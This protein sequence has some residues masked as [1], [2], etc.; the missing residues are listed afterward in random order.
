MLA[1]DQR[2]T[3]LSSALSAATIRVRG[4]EDAQVDYL[5]LFR[6]DSII[7]DCEAIRLALTHDYPEEKKQWSVTGQ[8]FGGFCETTYLSFFPEGLK[9][10][11]M[12]GG[13]PPLVDQP[14]Q[15][16]ASLYPRVLK[17]NAEY[18]EK[19][20]DDVARVKQIVAWLNLVNEEA[21]KGQVPFKVTTTGRKFLQLGMAF[22]THGGFDS[23][24]GT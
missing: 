8:S 2:G 6:A 23:V 3:G 15:V 19:Y 10:V 9:E 13:L 4:D 11:F 22:G 21:V 5:K 14:D 20:P 7:R 24:H 1:L 17:R 16:Y 18:Y 12:F